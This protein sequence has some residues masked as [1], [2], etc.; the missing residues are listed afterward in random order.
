MAVSEEIKKIKLELEKHNRLYYED[1]SPEITDAE[2]DAL[3]ARLKEL[4][5]N[6]N[7]DAE[8]SPTKKVGGKAKRSFEKHNHLKP[9]LSL[10]NVF[11]EEEFKK[12]DERVEKW[13]SEDNTVYSVEPKFDGIG[14]SITYEKGNLVRAV[15]RGDGL[16]G[17]LVTENILQIEKIP[18]KIRLNAPDIIELRGEIFFGLKDF[19]KINNELEKANGKK[20]V[21]PRNAAA[22]TIRNLDTEI[23]K[24]R[25]LDIFFYGIGGHSDDFTIGAHEDFIKYLKDNHFPVN[26]LINFCKKTHVQD[27]VQ[28]ILSSRESLNYEIDGA[29]V[30]VNDFKKQNKLGFVS[31]APRWAV[32]WK[33]PASE[34]YTKVN[35]VLFSVG[36]TGVVTPFAQ[37]EPVLLSGAKISNVSLHNMDE[38]KRLGIMVNDTVLVKRAGDV[39]PQITKVNTDVRNGSEKSINIPEYCP[40]CS[41]VLKTEGPFL[42]C[43]NGMKC[44]AQLF[45]FFEHF[46]S[47]KA[48]NIEGLGYK[49]NKHLINLGYVKEAADLFKLQN[50]ETELKALEGFGEKSIDNLFKSIEASRKPNLERF[51]NALGMPEV[52]ETTASALA[53]FFKD[54]GSLRKASFFDLM[55]MDNIG[56]VVAKNIIYFFKNET[57][58]LD[59]LLNEIE[60]QDFIVSKDSHLDNL[61][62]VITGSFENF[63]RD[64]LKQTIKEKGGIPSSSISSKTD[65]LILGEN[66]GSKFKKA[67]E[68]G[69]QVVTE[70]NIGKFLKL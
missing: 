44:P 14:I 7:S 30:K 47:R 43:D 31:K 2:Y 48:M 51:I 9:M 32:A 29:V 59:N 42:R 39:I 21:S 65:F 62:I 15:T 66:P 3:Y 60:I 37:I 19:E 69:I 38:L 46:V 12:F 70:D 34:K 6:S 61:K 52:G 36:R 4:E 11:S 8:D 26:D 53:R 10:N 18:K 50:F 63:S 68:L 55:Q 67:Q 58:G 25:P 28:K 57:I 64:E 45:G 1:D 5:K 24:S 20:F 35:D 41:N 23:V 49:I 16:T 22:G 13:V 27:Q 33:F 56:E 40:S 17:E 54:F